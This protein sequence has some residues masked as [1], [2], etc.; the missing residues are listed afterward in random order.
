MYIYTFFW[1]LE[2]TYNFQSLFISNTV[3][4][5]GAVGML[6]SFTLNIRVINIVMIGSVV[7]VTLNTVT[8]DRWVVPQH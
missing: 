1:D 7:S 6:D 8:I 5:I 4:N 2:P 3:I